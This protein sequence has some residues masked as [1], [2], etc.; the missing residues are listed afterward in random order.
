MPGLN[1][2]I[3]IEKIFRRFMRIKLP[4]KIFFTENLRVMIKAGLSLTEALHTLAL[5]TEHKGFRSII[6]ELN[7]DV[8]QG[9]NLSQ[10]LSRFKNVFEPIFINMIAAGEVSGTLEKTLEQLTVQMRKDYELVSKVKSAMTYPIVVL[11]ATVLIGIGMMIFVVPQILSIFEEMGDV[12]LPLPTRILIAAT[13]IMKHDWPFLI[14]GTIAI[15]GAFLWSIKRPLGKRVWHKF[16]LILPII[17]PIIQKINLAR[18]TRTLSSLLRTDIPIVQGL[19]ITSDIVR[20]VYY[21]DACLAMSEAVKKGETISHVLE[22]SPKLFPPLVIQMT[23]VGER[24]GTVDQMLEEIAEF[25]EKQ[26]DGIM[27][28]LSSII[29]PILI[30][31]LGGAVGGI[32]LAI[33][34]PIYSLTTQFGQ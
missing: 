22:Q 1:T 29:E 31:F 14:I 11:S 2:N 10:A 18:F 5:Q 30:I 25:Y 23:A 32:A 28:S 15:V 26:V 4:Q 21:H 3:P 34:T 13:D 12:E 33:I 27:G 24:A 7:S 6:E 17:G 20:N 8:E 9:K 19:T 16:L